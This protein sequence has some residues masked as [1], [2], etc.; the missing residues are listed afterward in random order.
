MP[1]GTKVSLGPGRIVL[2]ED[3]GRPPQKKK[4]AQSLIFGQCLLW[5]NGRPSQLLLILCSQNRQ[6]KL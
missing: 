6:L 1:L 3:P 2:H 4:S 5:S